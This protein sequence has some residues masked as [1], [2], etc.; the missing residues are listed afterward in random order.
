MNSATAEQINTI[1]HLEQKNDTIDMKVLKM[2]SA[3]VKG[4]NLKLDT[5]TL[6]MVEK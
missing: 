3:P 6:L 4:I 5:K 1:V 2:H